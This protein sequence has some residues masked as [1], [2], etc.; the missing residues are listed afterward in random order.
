[1]KRLVPAQEWIRVEFAP[2]M[3]QAA[4]KPPAIPGLCESHRPHKL[5]PL[6]QQV[7]EL[8]MPNED[9]DTASRTDGSRFNQGES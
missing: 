8:S 1:M 7:A 3:R 9:I 2:A 4:R 5:E 6:P